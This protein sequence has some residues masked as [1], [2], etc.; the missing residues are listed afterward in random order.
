MKTRNVFISHSW[1]HGGHYDRMVG[2]LRRRPYFDFRDYSVPS[3]NPL[4]VPGSN[5]ALKR[6]ITQKMEPCGTVLVVAGVHASNSSW[7]KEEI[8]IARNGFARPKPVIAVRPRGAE[9]TSTEVIRQ[10]DEVVGWSADSIVEAIRR[11]AP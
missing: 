5:A 2:L 8:E 3:W 9:R 1:K 6:A 7:M 10:A 11:H 4:D